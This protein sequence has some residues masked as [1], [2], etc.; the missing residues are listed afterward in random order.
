MLMNV[1]VNLHSAYMNANVEY[2]ISISF[3]HI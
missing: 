2:Y 3:L 1:K